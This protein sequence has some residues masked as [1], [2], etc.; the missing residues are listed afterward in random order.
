MNEWDWWIDYSLEDAKINYPTFADMDT[1]DARE[2]TLDEMRKLK[3]TGLDGSEYNPPI[4]FEDEYNNY[5]K[6]KKPV[7]YLFATTE[8]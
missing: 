3:Y 6:E 4:S 7:P 2:I 1:K 8:Y 5:I